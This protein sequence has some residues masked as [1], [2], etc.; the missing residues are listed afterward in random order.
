MTDSMTGVPTGAQGAAAPAFGSHP[1]AA[2]PAAAHPAAGHTAAP[3]PAG[4]PAPPYP[5][6]AALF[7]LTLA[8]GAGDY[9]AGEAV[10]LSALIED[11]ASRGAA[12]ALAELG[13][14]D[15]AARSDMTELR[16]L[17]GAWRDAKASARKAAI[18]WLVRGC[19]ALLLI[20][21]AVKLGLTGLVM[22]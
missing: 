10:S 13:L 19:L 20:G 3:H 12:R 5:T 1:A 9:R 8:G 17:L 15:A 2:H 18:S 21:L 11:A 22:K 4:H 6:G 7:G 14:S 16:E